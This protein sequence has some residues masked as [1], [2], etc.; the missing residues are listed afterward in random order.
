MSANEPRRIVRRREPMFDAPVVVL[1]LIVV[2]IAIYAAFNWA[3][4]AIQDRIIRDYAFIPGRLTIA[5]WPDRLVDLLNRVNTDPAALQQARQIRELHVL[6]GGAKPWTLL[7]Y[8]FLHGSWTHVL[9][10]TIWLVAF[11]PPIARRFGSA[12]FLLFMAVT[13]IASALAHW[14]VT[15]MDFSPLIGAS[16]ADWPHGRCDAIHVSASGAARSVRLD[17]PASDRDD[18]G[19][20]PA[21]RV[22]RASL[23]HFPSDLVGNEFYFRRRSSDARLFGHA[24]GVG[25]PYRRLLRWALAVPAVRSPFPCAADERRACGGSAA[26]GGLIRIS[27]RRP[28]GAAA[29]AQ[30]LGEK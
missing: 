12:R 7:T 20:S 2:L 11:G 8:A 1:G 30:T 22:C 13:A 16:G 14:A 24:G 4:E 26:N 6:S 27:R 10:N 15:P 25:R 28:P 19:R 23:A 5:I 17:Q 3:P 29:V 18:P 9:L 21:R